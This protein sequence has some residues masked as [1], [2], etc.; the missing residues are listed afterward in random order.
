MRPAPA[1]GL[2]D[3]YEREVLPR[4]VEQLDLD[5]VEE[6]RRHA[7]RRMNRRVRAIQP[8]VNAASTSWETARALAAR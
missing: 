7:R 5:P 1:P 3:R 4:L 6:V 8:C 2:V